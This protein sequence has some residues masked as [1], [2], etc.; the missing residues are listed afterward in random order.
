[1]ERITLKQ[2]PLLSDYLVDGGKGRDPLAQ[3]VH[4][5]WC[6]GTW[7]VLGSLSQPRLIRLNFLRKLC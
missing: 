3:T 2:M 5:L 7:F 4:S 1:M 6:M